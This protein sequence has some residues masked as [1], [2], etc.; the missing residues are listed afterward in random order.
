LQALKFHL[1][2]IC[3]KFPGRTSVCHY[4]SNEGFMEAQFTVSAGQPTKLK[5]KLNYDRQS[6]GQTISVSDTHLGPTPNFLFSLKFS[7]EI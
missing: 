2:C 7:L 4:R 1:M 5:L 6:V 3:R